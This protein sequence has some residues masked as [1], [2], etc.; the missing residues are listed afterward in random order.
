MMQWLFVAAIV[1]T[2]ALAD[3][4]QASHMRLQAQAGLSDAAVE[5]VRQ[6]RMILSVLCMAVSF[7]SFV[8]LLRTADLSF[9]VPATAV[10]FVLETAL[11]RWYLH[12]HVGGRRW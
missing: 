7:G 3:L 6:P 4:L 8:F 11:A 9:A 10:S 12:E 1:I 2:T 5:F